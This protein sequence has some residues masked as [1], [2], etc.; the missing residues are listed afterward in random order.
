MEVFEW[1]EFSQERNA[2]PFAYSRTSPSMTSYGSPLNLG[3][4]AHVDAGKT[5]L[6][7]R[8]L[9]LAGVTDRLGRVDDGDTQTDT[10]ALE[11]Q[12]GITI[13]A[14]VASFV[15]GESPHRTVVDLLDTPGHPDF[16]AEV[17]RV[18]GVLDGAVLV[19]SAVEGVQAQ[20]RVLMR[21]LRRLGIPVLV[22]VNK[23][24]RSGAAPATVLEAVATKLGVAVVGMSGVTGAGTREAAVS[25]AGAD[26]PAHVAAMINT[27][28]AH[29]DALLARYLAEPTVS[30]PCWR[31]ALADQT[32]RGLVHPVFF[33][34]ATTGAG[35]PELM[36]G[37]LEFLPRADGDPGADR[38]ATIFKIERGRAGE[39]IAYVRVFD[40]RLQVRDTIETDR[41]PRVIRDKITAL[42]VYDGGPATAAESVS[43]GQIARVWGLAAV[44]VG[45]IIGHPPRAVRDAFARPTLETLVRPRSPGDAGRLHA[46]LTQLAEQD[47]LIDF[48]RRGPGELSVSLY[49]EVQKEVIE[50]TL[51]SEYGVAVEFSDTHVLCL[52]RLRGVGHAV[53]FLGEGNPYFAT[54]G[55][56]VEPGPTGSGTHFGQET[57]VHGTLPLAFVNAISETVYDALQQ[58]PHGWE[59]TDCRVTLTHTGYYPRQSHAHAQ[60]DKSM[61]S[62]GSDFRSLT[63]LVLAQ[64]IGRAG[65]EVCEPIARVAVTVPTDTLSSVL[66]AV[67]RLG[68]I[69]DAPEITGP[70]T[71]VT[72]ELPVARTHELTS[73]LPGLT[74][75]EGFVEA[76]LD[77]YAPVRGPA[78][79]RQRTGPDPLDRRN[80]L[81]QVKR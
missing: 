3:I 67:A 66:S 57:S 14:A 49:G 15:I 27:L 44:Q 26:D 65:T 6:T 80:Y 42:E 25:T 62:V 76:E 74:H 54:V 69:P 53:E 79:R 32:R 52:E 35:V 2:P 16:I 18:L 41:S 1:D 56:R 30:Y 50:A 13:R 75:G 12:R 81:L 33:G 71:S 48:R 20:T 19:V 40:G 60:F 70:S 31:T 78:P 64:A 59:V 7:E 51:A 8:L 11:R 38:S 23:I 73:I 63:P 37:L 10:L 24:D 9:H 46:A 4:L 43:A 36:A 61:S 45:Q 47:P 58:G 22:F 39:K 17:E 28:T 77:H 29:D 68:G 34:S 55:L 21:T 5:S 72:G